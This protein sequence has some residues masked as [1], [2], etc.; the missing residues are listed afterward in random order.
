M[1]LRLRFNQY[2][3]VGIFNTPYIRISRIYVLFLT[4]L[5]IRRARKEQPEGY[6]CAA[7]HAC[8]HCSIVC[9]CSLGEVR[10]TLNLRI[11]TDP[12][13]L[14]TVDAVWEALAEKFPVFVEHG[15]FSRLDASYQPRRGSELPVQHSK[16]YYS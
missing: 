15:G 3:A 1:L 2:L 5:S 8:S 13:V 16:A 4:P 11:E 7:P 9:Q 12:D 14:R 10:I 6:D